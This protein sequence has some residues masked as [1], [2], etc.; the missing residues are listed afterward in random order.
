[1]T[2]SPTVPIASGCSQIAYVVKDIQASQK[3]FNEHLGVPR[4]Y[5]FDNIQFEDFTYRSCFTILRC[6]RG[7][8][9]IQSGRAGSNRWN[10]LCFVRHRD[11]Y[12][13][14]YRNSCLRRRHEEFVCSD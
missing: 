13:L 12:W 3:F 4:F 8:P 11:Y 1:M 9:L 2:D 7:Y 5:L 14:H 6:D 10:P